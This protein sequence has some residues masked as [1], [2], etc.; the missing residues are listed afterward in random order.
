MTRKHSLAFRI[1]A[2]VVPPTL[3][4]IMWWAV[5]T[6]PADPSIPRPQG[7]AE[8]GMDLI[9]TGEL[10]GALFTSLSRVLIGFLIAVLSGA[11]LGV[12][13]ARVRAVN[14]FLDPIIE[15]FRPVAPVALVPLAILW[16]GTGPEAAIGLIAYSAFFP[17]VVNAHASVRGLGDSL[18]NAART[19]GVSEYTITTQIVLPGAL[20]GLVV[21][22]R[23]GMGLGWAA[24]VA[25]ELAIGAG[26]GSTLGLGQLMFRFYQFE[27]DP[28]PI[29]VCMIVVGL[30]GLALD[31]ALRTIG[32]ILTPWL[33][34]RPLS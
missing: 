21:G 11:F 26:V 34:D 8:A 12:L 31:F 1:T 32:R 6:P 27:S 29:V 18:I 5:T 16:L 24:V 14:E 30:T 10:H 22:A 20:P 15:T 3:L 28:N 7:I 33:V 9:S 13:M 19:F 2:G 25:A 23:L 17:I 4:I